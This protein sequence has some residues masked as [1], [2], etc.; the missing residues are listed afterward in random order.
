MSKTCAVIA[1]WTSQWSN[2]LIAELEAR[3]LPYERSS[4]ATATIPRPA[5]ALLVIVNQTSR[6]RPRGHAGVLFYAEALLHHYASLGVP[7]INPV[8]AYRSEKSK[9]FQLD[10]LERVGARY[11]RTV[12]VNHR[13]KILKALDQ[14]PVPL[15]VKPNIGGSGAGIVRFDSR[16]DLEAALGGLDFGPDGTVLVQEYLESDESAIVRVEVMDGQ[17]L[18]AIRI[19][20]AAGGFNLCQA[21]ICRVP[22]APPASPLA[23]CPAAPPGLT[24]GASTPRPSRPCASSRGYFVDIG[25]VEYLVAKRDRQI[26]TATSALPRL[27]ANAP[28][29]SASTRPPTSSTTSP[30]RLDALGLV[31]WTTSIITSPSSSIS[32]VIGLGRRRRRAVLGER[33]VPAS[34]ASEPAFYSP[35]NTQS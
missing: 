18:Y 6:R 31:L 12:V 1:S 15:V 3:R 30:G 13:D 10:L 24:V 17:Y 2:R 21:D 26:T 11:P 8:A 23:A 16:E 28:E 35:Q 20:R 7:V 14:I 29:C 25:G 27:V 9:A 34:A 4:S 5:A 32:S 22:D 33:L 19:V